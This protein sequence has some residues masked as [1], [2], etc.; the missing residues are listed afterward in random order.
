VDVAEHTIELDGQPV[1]WRQAAGEEA[2]VLY[3]HGVPTSSDDW[4][5]LLARTGGIAPD[6]PGFGRSGKGGHLD[7]S[8]AGYSAFLDRFLAEIGVE[9]VRLVVHDWGAVALDWAQRH[10]ERIERLVVCNAVPLLPGYRWHPVAR[11]WR[12]PL[13]GEL[14]MGATTRWALRRVLGH[15]FSGPVPE[16]WLDGF[17]P[18]FDQ[19]TQR[20]ILRLYRSAPAS[21]LAAAGEHL[22]AIEAPALV[23]WGRGD[24]YIP[25]SF[26]EAY[27]AALPNARFEAVDASHWPWLERPE[28]AD[29]IAS[30]LLTG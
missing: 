18:H 16:A 15:G 13:V 9:R 30:F 14:T 8:I 10:P 2:P 12:M 23:L 1:F 27:A 11:A 22:G 20:A 3:V 28:V 29:C 4:T 6:L 26:G 19:G 21:V 25:T 7:Y 5:E 24:P 17:W